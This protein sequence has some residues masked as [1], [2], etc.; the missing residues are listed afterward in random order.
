MSHGQAGADA[1]GQDKSPAQRAVCSRRRALGALGALGALA[2]GALAPVALA[3]PDKGLTLGLASPQ[4]HL[5]PDPSAYPSASPP[6]PPNPQPLLDAPPQ[7]LLARSWVEGQS[8]KGFLVSE[9]Y[10]GVRGVWDGKVL[11]F[12]SGRVV[13]APAWFVAAL[14]PVALDGELWIG[15]GQFDRLSGLVRQQVPDDDLWRLVS[16]RI[17]DA[18]QHSGT[19]AE[20]VRFVQTTLAAADV[21]WLKPVAHETVSSA[22]ALK[23]RLQSVLALGGEGLM[24][25]RADAV[26]QAG[27]NDALYKYKHEVDAEA[28][29]VGHVPGQGR[30]TGMTGSLLVQMPSGQRFALGSGLTDALRRKPPPV[31][32]WVTYRYRGYTPSGLPRFASFVRVR[33]SE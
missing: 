17:F 7:H 20:R 23:A 14:P 22:D 31:G 24:L 21:A 16:Y 13:A 1:I 3:Q 18:P 19:F 2:M 26:W 33:E 32:A 6:P 28:Q 5:P 27:R 30:L 12:R 9:K 8:P 4:P 15:R 10:D 11:R 25:H 29:V